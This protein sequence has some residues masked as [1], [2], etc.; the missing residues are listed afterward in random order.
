MNKK[1]I[2][3][4]LT[5]KKL[6]VHCDL[7]NKYILTNFFNV[8]QIKK[9]ELS[10]CS[11]ELSKKLN[12]KQMF[13]NKLFFILFFILSSNASSIYHKNINKISF[14]NENEHFLIKNIITNKNLIVNFLKLLLNDSSINLFL[15]KNTNKLHFNFKK[16]K[17]KI[18]FNF[19][20]SILHEFF[21]AINNFSWRTDCKE[22]KVSVCFTLENI[23]KRNF[24]LKQ[25][26]NSFK[27]FLFF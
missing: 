7:I 19:P 4:S 6:L 2:Y 27:N 8:P 23:K 1:K 20:L 17:L 25:I 16:E 10:I 26:K 15:Q 22:E 18:S 11:E 5:K 14:L 9:I 12:K 24:S 21:Y 3:Y 13:L